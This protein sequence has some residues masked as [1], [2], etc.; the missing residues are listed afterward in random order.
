MLEII[1]VLSHYKDVLDISQFDFHLPEELI[2]QTPA[3]KREKSRLLVVDRQ[4]QQVTHHVFEELPDLLPSP[5]DIVR[6]DAKVL[7]ARI[8]AQR[9]TGGSVECLLLSP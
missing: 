8:H 4:K 6:N 7:K 2:A 9:P 5:L 3:E 1:H